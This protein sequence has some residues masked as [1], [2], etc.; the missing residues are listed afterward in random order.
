MDV[1]LI[2]N[3]F[4]VT[5]MIQ[6][7]HFDTLSAQVGISAIR[8]FSCFLIHHAEKV[9]AHER[10]KIEYAESVEFVNNKYFQTMRHFLVQIFCYSQIHVQNILL[11]LLE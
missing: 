8:P 2:D 7:V 3:L 1:L 11:K 6:L 5:L 9:S 4:S 10:E